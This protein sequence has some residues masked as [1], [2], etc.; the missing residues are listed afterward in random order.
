[1]EDGNPD[2]SFE[3]KLIGRE[4][5]MNTLQELWEETKKGNGSTVFIS[6]EAGVGKTRLIEEFLNSKEAKIIKGWCLAESMEPLI[7]FR[8]ALKDVGL[9]H[10]ISGKPNPKVISAYLIDEAGLLIVKAER[11][12][13]EL[14]PDIFAS[15][16]TAVENFVGDSLELM[17]RE[18][19]SKLQS[20][21]YGGYDLVIQSRFGM[22]LVTVIEGENSEF[23]IQD[24]K[25]TL[26]HIN[27]EIDSCKGDV[28]KEKKIQ[29]EI[30]WFI[31]SRKY[32]GKRLVDDPKIKQ[33]NVFDNVLLGLRRISIKQPIIL[34]IDDLQWADPTTLNLLHF[35]SRNTKD[36]GIMILGSYRPEDIGSEG[37]THPLKTV[38]HN[39]NREGLFEEIELKRLGRAA[40]DEVIADSL[41]ETDI[42]DDFTENVFEES[43]GNP[44]FLLEIIRMLVE[45]EHLIKENGIWREVGDVE[46]AR[47]PS[48]VYDVVSRRLDRLISEQRDLLECSSVVGEEFESS[49]VGEVTEMNRMKLLKNL[50]KIEKNHHLI[51]SIK[52]KYR[53]DHTKIREVLYN[54]INSELRTEYHRIIA[55]SY[56]KLYQDNIEQYREHIGHHYL[57]AGDE[58]G[59][60]HLIQLGEKAKNDYA[61][62]EAEQFYGDALSLIG[63]KDTERAKTA[64]KDLGDVYMVV[65]RY[66]KALTNYKIA[67]NLTE[68]DLERAEL[69]GNIGGTLRMMGE[70]DD[71]LEFVDKGISLTGEND[72]ERCRLLYKKGWMFVRQGEY[73]E[74]IRVFDEERKLARRLGEDKERGQALHDLGTVYYHKGEYDEAEKYF[75]EAIKFRRETGDVEGLSASFNNLGLVYKNQGDLEKALKH[76]EK[77]LKI[78]EEIGGKSTIAMALNNIGVIHKNKGDL[79]KALDY[80]EQTLDIKREIGDKYG[81]AMALNNI[82]IILSIQ[83]DLDEA[84]NYYERTIE[85]QKEIGEK[86]G[87]AM[88]HSNMGENYFDRGECNEALEHFRMSMEIAEEIGERWLCIYNMCGMAETLVKKKEIKKA[89]ENA[90]EALDIA[91]DIGAIVEE[92]MSRR[93]LGIVYRGQE[94]WDEA[95]DEFK[96]AIQIF[97][98]KGY[99]RELSRTYFEYG[100]LCISMGRKEDGKVLIDKA[101][102]IFEDM[103]MKTDIERAEQVLSSL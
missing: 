50:N 60:D 2:I 75:L 102:E 43:E 34:F 100:L 57:L 83:G 31:D 41:G 58:R 40:V 73:D 37:Q 62:E 6:G 46:E 45:E 94:R 61:N 8:E 67:L 13:T 77:C 21:E 19:K 20:I 44:Y 3:P 30:R 56:E 89:E 88:S 70:Y 4:R 32:E 81:I 90:A 82:G 87:I 10:F 5:E 93:T 18:G 72:V 86:Y 12:E 24:M 85:I 68:D 74:A 33:E 29:P 101:I 49:V 84:M 103:N 16:L 52:K 17:G 92:G 69:Y 51:H 23:L 26:L 25:K 64:H 22:S 99:K 80:Y 97:E 39:M 76:Y 7:P 71:A 15:M 9:Y 53:F 35:L 36:N 47:I 63:D 38:M 96:I 55:E 11:E 59:I 66:E 78:A 79:K 91:L 65:G 54:E 98:E 1:M 14:D 27:N 48:R 28:N 42:E 95:E